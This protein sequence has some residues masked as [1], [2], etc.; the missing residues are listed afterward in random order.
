MTEAT[1]ETGNGKSTARKKD[2][3]GAATATAEVLI[4]LR[5]I[6]KTYERAGEKLRILENL[7][8]D[9]HKGSF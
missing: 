9:V 7:D 3:E 4:K 8:L 6:G 5:G 2:D 1:S